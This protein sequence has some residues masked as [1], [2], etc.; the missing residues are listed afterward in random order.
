[1]NLFPCHTL[2]YSLPVFCVGR[3]CPSSRQGYSPQDWNQGETCKDVQDHPWR[4]VRLWLQDSVWR[5]QDNRLCHGVRLPR[6]RQEEWAQTQTGQSEFCIYISALI[7]LSTM[8]REL[9]FCHTLFP[10]HIIDVL[11]DLKC[12]LMG[13]SF[14]LKAFGNIV[15]A[16]KWVL[17]YHIACIACSAVCRRQQISTWKL[18]WLWYSGRCDAIGSCTRKWKLIIH[19]LHQKPHTRLEAV[20]FIYFNEDVCTV[21]TY[22]IDIKSLSS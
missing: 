17:M 6:L 4:C 21:P 22:F 9:V 18:E 10:S 1:M 12:S 3:R 15:E 11:C 8:I 2:I 20:G 13:Y 14:W 16:L 7:A 5:R 19:N